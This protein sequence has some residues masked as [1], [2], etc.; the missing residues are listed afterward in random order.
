MK[1]I[2]GVLLMEKQIVCIASDAPQDNGLGEYFVLKGKRKMI[3]YERLRDN[4]IGM[5]FNH[6]TVEDYYTVTG[7]VPYGTICKCRCDCGRIREVSLAKL[8]CKKGIKFCGECSIK[9]TPDDI[10]G[11]VMAEHGVPES[12]WTVLCLHHTVNKKQ[13]DGERSLLRYWECECSCENRTHMVIGTKDLISG[14]SLSC[15]CEGSDKFLEK[16]PNHKLNIYDLSGEYGIGYT[17]NTNK[18]F[19]FDLED[20]DKIKDHC[21]M[22]HHPFP[23]YS[24]LL[25]NIKSEKGITKSVRFHQ[26][27][28]CSHYDHINHDALDNRKENLR[29]CSQHQNTFNTRKKKNNTS[30]VTG[31]GHYNGKGERWRARL[32]LNGK[33]INLGSYE[34]FDE[35]VKARLEGEKTYYGE[36]APQRHLFAQYGV[37]DDNKEHN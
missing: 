33:E 13:S 30:G 19:Y 1:K 17:L 34:T 28:G 29:P 25:S 36:F 11:W 12:R 37:E 20:Y 9:R 4:I 10:T 3:D 22:E 7:S 23:N 6:L 32:M 35:A 31:V 2:T 27:I 16:G 15:G 8:V 18:P 26:L 5:K 14:R 21:W 24:V